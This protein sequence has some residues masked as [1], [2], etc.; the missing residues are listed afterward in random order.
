MTRQ[1]A[2]NRAAQLA[3]KYPDEII[4]VCELESEFGTEWDAARESIADTWS[5]EG[6]VIRWIEWSAA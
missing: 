4:V 2:N 5:D 1:Q 3:N 6:R